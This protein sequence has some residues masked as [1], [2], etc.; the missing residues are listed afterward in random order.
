M[1]TSISGWGILLPLSSVTLC[2]ES[3]PGIVFEI[4]PPPIRRGFLLCSW[5][6]EK[7]ESSFWRFDGRE[8]SSREVKSGGGRK[9]AVCGAVSVET[10]VSGCAYFAGV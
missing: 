9:V 7:S 4:F 3:S 8:V 10:G 2:N 1:R 5:A 6:D